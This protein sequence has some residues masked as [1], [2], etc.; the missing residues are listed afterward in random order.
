M[1]DVT[2][3]PSRNPWREFN[4]VVDAMQLDAVMEFIHPE[5]TMR[6]SNYPAAIG[7]E[8]I[9]EMVAAAFGRWKVVN[10][11][12]EHSWEEGDTTIQEQMMYYV[13]PDG[14]EV[15]IP[16][17]TIIQWKDGLLY[18]HRSFVDTRPIE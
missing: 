14:K 1:S 6:Y 5:A 18:R 12:V 3:S 16:C 9:R 17:V 10:H 8:K 2:T 7:K 4:K 13:M 11:N 15:Q